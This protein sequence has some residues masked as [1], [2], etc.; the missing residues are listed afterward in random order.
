V[1]IH[2]I[3]IYLNNIESIYHDAARCCQ[4]TV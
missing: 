3:I 4:G 2:I 1:F